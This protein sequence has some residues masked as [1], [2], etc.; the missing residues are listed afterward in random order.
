MTDPRIDN[1]ARIM[2]EYSLRL[3]K[4]ERVAITGSTLAAPLMLAV[5]RECLRAGA[6]PDLMPVLPG[7]QRLLLD[8]GSIS[9]LG[10]LSPLYRMVI[11]EYDAL[12]RIGSAAN[13]RS[14]NNV[15]P[16]RQRTH[17]KSLSR[18]TKTRFERGAAGDFR[19]VITLFPTSA[20]AQDAEMSLQEF[21]DYVYH[22]TFAD[23]ED[24]IGAW[25]NLHD[26]QQ[27]YVDWLKG[28]SAVRVTGPHVDLSLSIEGRTF[29]NS[30]GDRNMPSGEIFTGP[31]EQSVNG[32]IRFQYPAIYGGHQVEDVRLE[33]ERGKV[34][35]ATAKKN[36]AFLQQMIATDP[37]ASYLGEFAMGTNQNINR[38]IGNILFDEKIG[39]T[40]HVALGRGYPET[41]SRN[42]SAIH[43]DMICDMRDGGEIMVDDECIYQSGRFLI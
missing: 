9:Q 10:Y 31:V 39:G 26:E 17:A 41:G 36:E 11:E 23:N 12:V 21:E 32:W 3:Q 8:E 30:D 38:F 40:I 29:R 22:A 7:S 4:G 27:R 6:H 2:V 25:Q 18:L 33:F 42:E 43:W 15:D 28:K 14:N 20:Y 5:Q 37:G 16:L 1:L 13:T 19:W 24:P 35:K 34:V